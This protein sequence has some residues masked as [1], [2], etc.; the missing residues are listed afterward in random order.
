MYF[1]GIKQFMMKNL[2]QVL[3]T[4]FVV[5]LAAAQDA[6]TREFD[7]ELDLR[8]HPA[9]V[10]GVVVDQMRYDY[11]T[12]FWDKF[13]EDGFKRLVSEGFN[14][15]NNHYNY[16]P[17]Y[18]GPG[19]ASIYTGASPETHGIIS[20]DWYNKFESK[21]VYC[22]EDHSVKSIGTT[23]KAG[24]MSPHRLLTASVSDENRLHTQMKGKTIGIA[25]KDRGAIL[26]AGHTANAAYW[27]H[28]K[29]EGQWISSS[30][31]MQQ[32]P[33]WV[34]QFNASGKAASYMKNWK[35]LYDINTY[36]ESGSDLNTFEGGFSGKKDAGFPYDLAKLQKQ[37]GGFDLLKATPFGN[38]LTADFAIA[39]IDGEQFR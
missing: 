10:V 13:S 28:G 22:V 23:S 35:T 32:L 36:T 18:T 25:L 9:L 8:A 14:C 33:Q 37:N 20:N 39:A 17:T 19:H 38:S 16:I 24:E 27:F 6:P 26:P 1:W 21:M 2:F 3:L 34:K 11:I 30:F 4:F 31:Y 7:P 15:R 5:Q 29:D 12:R